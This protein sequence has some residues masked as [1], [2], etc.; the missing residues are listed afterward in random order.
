[1]IAQKSYLPENCSVRG[2]VVKLLSVLNVDVAL[3]G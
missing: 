3:P 2:V 1:M